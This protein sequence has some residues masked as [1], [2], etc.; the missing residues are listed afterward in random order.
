M[1]ISN[2]LEEAWLKTLRGGGAGT[3]FTAPTT[4][5]LKLHTGDPGEEQDRERRG[6]GHPAGDHQRRA[7]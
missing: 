1:S 3:T 7:R 6:G 4:I 2:Y 5:Y